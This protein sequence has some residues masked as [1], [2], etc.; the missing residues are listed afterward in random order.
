[1]LDQN[2][3]REIK[4]EGK[5]Q[6]IMKGVMPVDADIDGA[7]LHKIVDARLYNCNVYVAASHSQFIDD[8]WICDPSITMFAYSPCGH[9]EAFR[10]TGV[11]MYSYSGW[12]DGAYPHSAIK[13]H[14]TIP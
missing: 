4:R 12:F 5:V 2:T 3:S 1:M 11:P 8:V 10:E 6:A 7:L 14:I 9:Q 13:R